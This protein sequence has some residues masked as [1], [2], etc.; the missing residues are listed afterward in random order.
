VSVWRNTSASD[1]DS[2][3]TS[4]VGRLSADD[5]TA[6]QEFWQ[7][8][9]P[10]R[11]SIAA[12]VMASASR[13]P[14]W[15]SILSLLAEDAHV[16]L[17]RA[18]LDGAWEPFLA[19]LQAQGEAFAEAG[20]GYSVWFDL[21]RAFRDAIREE[22]HGYFVE[23]PRDHLT[24]VLGISRGMN[25]L[26][27]IA[28][29]RIGDAYLVTKQRLVATSDA[30]SRAM[31]DQSPVPMWMFDRE[32]LRF[33]MVNDAAIRHYG[34]SR[35]EFMAMTLAD[36]RRADDIVSLRED[37]ARTF[38]L[39]PART[40]QHFKKDGTKISVELSFS[41]FSF[42][43]RPIR[44][45]LIADITDRVKAEEAL[46]KT[47]DQLL[48][49]QKMEAIGRLAGGVAHD[50]N[51][52]LTV[53]QS[54]ACLLEENIDATDPRRGDVGEIRRASERARAITRQLLTVS[55]H[56]VVSP[57]SIDLDELVTGFVPMLRRLLG[58]NVSL[59]TYRG[60]VPKVVVDQ[61]QIEQVLMNLAVNARDAMPDGGRFTIESRTIDIENDPAA[62]RQL[63]A[64]RYVELA[65]TD[66]GTGIDAETQR[67]IFDP[68]FTTKDVGVGT[69]LGLSIVHGIISQAG[70]AISVYSERGHGTTFRILL[71]V[72]ETVPAVS[73]HPIV[74]APRAL[75]PLRIL[76]VDDQADV[77]S[78]AVRILKDAGCHVIEAA[79]AD[80]AL[81]VGVSEEETIDL[82]L[83]DVVL[84]DVRGDILARQLRE[85][86]PD[87]KILHMSGYPAG[88]LAPSGAFSTELLTKPFSPSDLR[89]AVAHV[90]GLSSHASTPSFDAPA[91]KP[92]TMR[93]ALVADDDE[94]FRRVVVRLLRKADFD[95][96]DVDSGY[97]AITALEKE[98]FDVVVSDVQM[99]DGG[100]LDLL[101][102]VRRVDL[103]VPVVLM[104]GQ[105]SLAAAADAVEYGAFRYLTKPLDS[106]AFTRTVNHAARA[107]A[108]ARLRREAFSVSGRHAGIAD[109]AGL[110]VRFEKAIEGLSMVFQPIVHARTGALFGVEALMRTSE[111]S[112][113]TPDAVLDAASKLGRLPLVGR[114]VRSLCGSIFAA[115]SDN[116]VLFVNLHPNDL[117]DI[118][119][120]DE[121][122]VLTT[123]AS[124]VIL[125]VTERASLDSSQQMHER[126]GRLRQLGF[127]LAI[128]DIGAGYS[129]L[130][131]FTELTPEIVKIDMTLVRDVHTSAAKQRTIGAL[132]RLC[133]EAGTLVVAEGVETLDERDTLVNLGCDLLQ[134]YL[135]GKPNRILP[136]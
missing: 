103:D 23:A 57:Q 130:T 111:P 89:A 9:E 90:C 1:G 52:I 93:R 20:I 92:R 15:S 129:G 45:V 49:A 44:H 118:D 135:L 100:G 78:V 21:T 62:A 7:F 77:R 32:T 58:E 109:R 47:H 116:T 43:G 94:S 12:R 75:P 39:K 110:E 26:L 13:L 35:E 27:D 79:S 4:Y 51:N 121:G 83:L 18:V 60:G 70:G 91:D 119:L 123:I 69:G 24:S 96:L 37:V 61:G 134:G 112:L 19:R 22:L 3:S 117:H 30:R 84:S 82:V 105:P 65:V 122:A 124:R 127:R 102:A 80:E 5:K 16:L 87:V 97:K 50:F 113:P 88:A 29:E 64:G 72:G 76:V 38:G 114:K 131:S 98:P 106:Q 67:R 101:R 40:P 125:E 68:F 56:G 81:K 33:V 25:H 11:T 108:L 6:I 14:E 74:V 2:L 28:I 36:I 8:Y 41:D 120:I 46:Q 104:T 42:A 73:A 86:R 132:C 17:Q 34:Y 66:T 31:F 59:V 63:K 10:R 95:V 99:P 136:A 107:H 128:D 48:H 71:P 53:V 85:L 115:R 55:R 126:I 133:H 54:Y